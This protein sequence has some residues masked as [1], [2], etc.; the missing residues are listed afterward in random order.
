MGRRV[1]KILTEKKTPKLEV[2]KPKEP[3]PI[4]SAKAKKSE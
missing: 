3:T 1:G 2:E 4:V